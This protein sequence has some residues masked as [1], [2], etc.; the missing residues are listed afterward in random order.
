M[1][2]SILLQ[3]ASTAVRLFV[4]NVMEAFRFLAE[5]VHADVETVKVG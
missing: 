4:E 5:T 1:T 2:D 3:P